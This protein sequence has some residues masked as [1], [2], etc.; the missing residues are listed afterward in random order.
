MGLKRLRLKTP[1]G[2]GLAMLIASLSLGVFPVGNTLATPEAGDFSLWQ[3]PLNAQWQAY[4]QQSAAD[5]ALLQQ[6]LQAELTAAKLSEAIPATKAKEF[7]IM[8]IE[9]S[10]TLAA[11]LSYQTVL[12]GWSKRTD[13]RQP[14][15]FGQLAGSEPSYIP[16]F[17][18]GATSTQIRWLVAYYPK[19]SPTDQAKI[20]KALSQAVQFILRAQYPNGGFAQSY[21]LRGSYH[22]A[23]T[24]NDNVMTDL[25]RVL[26]DIGYQPE[27]SWLAEDLRDNART[28]FAKGVRWLLSAQVQVNDKR[29]IWAAQHHPQT[30]EPVAARKFEKV[31]LVSSESAAVLQLL[32]E[33]AVDNPGVLSALCDGVAWLEQHQITDKTWQKHEQGSALVEKKG[34]LTWARFYS[35]PQQQPVFFDR[36]G[37]T[38]HDVNQLSLERQHGYAWYQSNA[39][40]LLKSWQKQPQLAVQCRQ[41]SN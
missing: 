24:L 26:W 8:A 12:G 38:Y 39:K 28:A 13:M 7:G 29:T 2:Y 27:L 14:R 36:D 23:V 17:D 6:Q 10:A 21:P 34:S 37:Q 16:T 30:G 3:Q 1:R 32:L 9:D 40:K 15:Q 41:G 11:V 19:A 31:S 25:L 33:K 20:R 35:L 5:L 18:N 4:Q 22:D